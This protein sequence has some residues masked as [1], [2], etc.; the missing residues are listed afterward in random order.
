MQKTPF[1]FSQNWKH[2][3]K[4]IEE[5]EFLTKKRKY[6]QVVL[7]KPKKS[8]K[9]T[10]IVDNKEYNK[11]EYRILHSMWNTGAIKM[12]QNYFQTGTFFFSI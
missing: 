5:C 2:E 7:Y 12:K 4:K 11:I 3:Q 9:D 1:E 6:N 10:K 8:E